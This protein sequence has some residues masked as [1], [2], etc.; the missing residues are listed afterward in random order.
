MQELLLSNLYLA[1][2]SAG[3]G[4]IVGCVIIAL[5]FL[6]ILFKSAFHCGVTVAQPVNKR[7]DM[8]NIG[9]LMF[10]FRYPFYNV[11]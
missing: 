2:I 8:I 1:L 6:L 7:I 3:L 5:Q 10:I 4:S 11:I 9:V